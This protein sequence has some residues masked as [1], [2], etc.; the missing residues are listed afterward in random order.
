MKFIM[1]FLVHLY[2][3]RLEAYLVED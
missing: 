3:F 2:Q 1:N